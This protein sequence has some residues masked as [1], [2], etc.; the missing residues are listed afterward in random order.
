MNKKMKLKEMIVNAIYF[1]VVFV[2]AVGIATQALAR[3]V[4]MFQTITSPVFFY[5]DKQDITIPTIVAGS[6]E[7]V[8]STP[9]QHVNKGDLIMRINS[10]AFERKIALLEKVAI[11]NLSAR[12][13]LSILKEKRNSYN[14][15]APQDGVI[16]QLHTSEGSYLQSGENVFTLFA[17]RD[18]RLVSYVTPAQYNEIQRNSDVNV[19]S[20]R[21]E[22][23]FHVKLD[24]I[25][26]VTNDPIAIQ[27]NTSNVAQV[28]K[29]ELIFHFMNSEDGAVFIEQESLQLIN[30]VE[31]DAIKRPMERIAHLWNALILGR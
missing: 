23:M 21:L 14:I 22:Q 24:G 25:G 19:Y 2:F 10:E 12:T 3:K 26:R 11:N 17:D 8:L 20:K 4:N 31:D 16:Y 13:E 6:V 7:E 9:G 27:T 1:V 28:R 5:V 18:A 29:Y 15:Y 30:P